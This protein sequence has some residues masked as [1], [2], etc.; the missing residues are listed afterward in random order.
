[1]V[2][3]GKLQIVRKLS[4]TLL[5]LLFVVALAACGSNS[6]EENQGS[7]ANGNET[8]EQEK[9]ETQG[10]EEA[11]TGDVVEVSL[12]LSSWIGYAPLYIGVEKGFFEDHGVKMDLKLMENVA[13]RRSA[14][15][16]NIIQGFTTTVDTHVVTASSDIPVVQVVALDDSYGGD[17]LVAKKEF[18]SIEDLKGKK[19]AAQTDGGASFFWFLTLLDERGIDIDEFDMQSMSAGDAGAAFV[20]GKV[21]AAATWEPWLTNA[22]QTDFGHVII[23]SDETPGVIADSIGLRQDFVEENPEAVQGIVDGW[24]DSVEFWKENPDEANEIMARNVGMT[25]EEFEEAL[26][27]VRYYDKERNQEY[28]GTEDNPG[29]LRALTEKAARLWKEQGIIDEE[30]DIDAMIDYRFVQ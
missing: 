19:V 13:D 21:D 29:D 26:A 25:I 3:R 30:P 8:Q 11:S 24:F 6:A 20:A 18:K 14:M 27:G 7:Q 4:F 12:A 9:E 15:A 23:S 10:T 17:G 1:M 16:S 28:F 2:M 5:I 22:K